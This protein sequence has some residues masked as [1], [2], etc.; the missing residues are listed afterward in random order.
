MYKGE[1]L[2]RREDH[3]EEERRRGGRV[4]HSGQ[5]GLTCVSPLTGSPLRWEGGGEASVVAPDSWGLEEEG[6]GSQETCLCVFASSPS[7]LLGLRRASDVTSGWGR[8]GGGGGGGRVDEQTDRQTDR[9][10]E[11]DRKKTE[12]ENHTLNSKGQD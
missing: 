4:A 6:E 3:K 12:K 10:T 9:K 11:T 2:G 8:S 1:E 5:P 7:K